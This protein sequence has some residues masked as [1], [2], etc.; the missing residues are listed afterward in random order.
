MLVPLL[1]VLVLRKGYIMLSFSVTRGLLVAVTAG[2]LVAGLGCESEYRKTAGDPNA[3]K[4]LKQARL[5]EADHTV[6][7]FKA[8]DKTMAKFFDNAYGYAVFPE[9]AKGGAGI[10]G[11]HGH[12]V[13]FEKGKAVGFT[14][15]SQ[16]TIGLQLGGQT[17]RE[18][19][20]FKDKATLEKFKRSEMEFAAQATAVAADEGK[21]ANADF[22]GGL[23][24]FTLPIKGLMGEASAGGQKFTYESFK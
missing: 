5:Q 9:I 20:F 12:G 18:I 23:A 2:L 21:S 24:V 7:A 10:G 3:V 15:M 4:E 16:G 8:K 14:D 1:E 11:A 17:Y 13:V 19:I 22:Q 6:A